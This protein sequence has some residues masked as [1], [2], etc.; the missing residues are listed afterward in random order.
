MPRASARSASSACPWSRPRR[1]RLGLP[2]PPPAAVDTPGTALHKSGDA[3]VGL[4]S[5]S[6]YRV[7]DETDL[8]KRR[9][10]SASPA[11]L[12]PLNGR[13]V[14]RCQK[15]DSEAELQRVLRG[16]TGG[17]ARHG[18][19]VGAFVK[20]DPTAPSIPMKRT[21]RS[22]S[23]VFGRGPR[24]TWTWSWAWAR[25]GMP[26][27]STTGRR[28]SRTLPRRGASVSCCRPRAGIPTKTRH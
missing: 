7:N 1:R 19:L 6:C 3:A 8:K 11:V 12:K 13:A 16:C 27:W 25:R 14:V 2:G 15:V 18:R 10:W 20:K 26:K 21:R 24:S 17:D 4:P 5:P 28:R 23:R 22:C 9:L